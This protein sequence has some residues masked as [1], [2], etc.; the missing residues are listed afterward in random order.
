[1]K[2]WQLVFHMNPYRNI[3][4]WP[5]RIYA[6]D[7]IP[8]NSNAVRLLGP[9]CLQL[10]VINLLIQ[11]NLGDPTDPLILNLA[12]SFTRTI[13]QLD[14][15]TIGFLFVLL[16]LSLC[17]NRSKKQMKKD[18]RRTRNF[19]GVNFP[20]VSFRGALFPGAF[21]RGAFFPGAFFLAP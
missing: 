14:Y 19:P 10:G 5:V 18:S 3:I 7:E 15:V 2:I 13:R 11:V 17:S 12:Q 6:R 20:G 9:I 21:F 1:M 4:N 8:L 16:S